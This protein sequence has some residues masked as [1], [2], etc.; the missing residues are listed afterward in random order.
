MEENKAITLDDIIR[1]RKVIELWGQK[2]NIVTRE[3]PLLPAGDDDGFNSSQVYFKPENLQLTGAYKIRGMICK[4]ASVV[5]RNINGTLMVSSGNGGKAAAFLSQKLGLESVIIV[6]DSTP[7]SKVEQI[8]SF[9]AEVIKIKFT[10]FDDLM[11]E[12]TTLCKKR[13]LEYINPFEEPYMMAGAGT[14]GLE[15]V[16]SMQDV[17]VVVIPVGT[18][19]GACGIATAVK[20]LNSTIRVYA[21]G[22]ES[23]CFYQS[24][25]K[26]EPV[27]LDSIPE[28][29]CG[30]LKSPLTTRYNL[31]QGLKYIDDVFTVSEAETIDAMKNLWLKEHLVVEPGGSVALAAL[32]ANKLPLLEN[33]KVVCVLTGGNADFEKAVEY[34]S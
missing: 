25:R 9:G 27:I 10:S 20:S 13:S 29:I 3:T 8:A 30:P 23:N 15:V 22:Q 7:N 21:V 19:T 28:T 6:P 17:D 11:N 16:E 24:F 18:G 1:A 34:F 32:R 14:V 5:D 31:D 33:Q 26:K 2:E 12:T 4:I